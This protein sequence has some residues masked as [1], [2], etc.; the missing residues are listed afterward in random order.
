MGQIQTVF[1]LPD[2]FVYDPEVFL[3]PNL[4]GYGRVPDLWTAMSLDAELK[5]MVKEFIEGGLSEIDKSYGKSYVYTT[6]SAGTGGANGASVEYRYEASAF[7]DIL[8]R[9][10]GV[11]I[12][13]GE[14]DGAQI[15]ATA[16]GF[17]NRA[18]LAGAG[19]NNPSFQLLFQKFA[20][21][22]AVCFF[23]QA[24]ALQMSRGTALR[25][26]SDGSPTLE[27]ATLTE[28]LAP[29]A[30]MTFDR[31]TD[32]IAGNA[33]TLLDS[34]LSDLAFDPADPWSG[35]TQWVAE[36]KITLDIVD[37]TRTMLME[38]HRARTGNQALDILLVAHSEQRGTSGD[39][40]LL[41]DVN[42]TT[43]DLLEGKA[44]NDRLEGGSGN[45]TYVFTDGFGSDVVLDSAGANDEIAFQGTLTYDRVHFAYANGNRDNLL[46]TFDGTN[47][48]IIVLGYFT[49]SGK[50]TIE[51]I[52]FPDGSVASAR[53]IVD[54]VL[55]GLSGEE[56]DNLRSYDIGSTL[57]G[58][59]GDDD[60][61]GRGG[62]DVLDGGAGD[63]TLSGGGGDD[64]YRF[65]HG[66]GQDVITDYSGSGSWGGND[67]VQFREGVLIGDVTVTQVNGGND[68]LLT[69][70]GGD[71]ITLRGTVTNGDNRIEQVSFANGTIWNHAQLM[72]YTS[73]PGQS[74]GAQ[75]KTSSSSLPNPTQ[76]DG[77][78]LAS[79]TMETAERPKLQISAISPVANSQRNAKMDQIIAGMIHAM[80]V[81][82]A[83]TGSELSVPC[84]SASKPVEF[85]A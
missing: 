32:S 54:D 33:A 52:S 63:D 70:A 69:I 4:R 78:N 46:I 36:H 71:S 34:E 2:G 8:A 19:G 27:Q 5:R 62:A 61:L 82:G 15:Q 10:A 41:G 48:Q 7:E 25:F 20:A 77:A 47:D 80:S 40:I 55:A 74:G 12:S 14:N 51:K 56:P 21:N 84:Y 44:G 85:Y 42:G 18:T 22:E 13:E 53:R 66:D 58:K 79:D 38:R 17:M 31:R 50:G 57:L 49:S 65:G 64:I 60:L 35:F 23:V 3:L 39:D 72:L 6:S 67:T 37:P 29:F 75:N 76:L 43:A 30:G 73:A 83:E 24:A 59:G 11:A 26:E 68:L 28:N 9:W 16:E 81:F 45:D 1:N